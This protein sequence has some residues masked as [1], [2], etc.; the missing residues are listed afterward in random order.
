MKLFLNVAIVVSFFGLVA[1]AIWLVWD[2]EGFSNAEK[3]VISALF[4]FVALMLLALGLC[5]YKL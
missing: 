5:L 4:V 1:A 2:Q 3:A